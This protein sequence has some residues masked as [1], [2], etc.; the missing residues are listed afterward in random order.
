LQAKPRIEQPHVVLF[1]QHFCKSW[2]LGHD[3]ELH[4]QLPL[5]QVRLFVHAC[6]HDPQLLLSVCSATHAPLQFV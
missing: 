1:L 4:E 2:Q 5:W 3:D 6:P